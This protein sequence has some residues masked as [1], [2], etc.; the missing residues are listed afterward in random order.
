MKGV[1]GDAGAALVVGGTSGLGWAL[2]QA[3][4]QRGY[5]VVITG[6]SAERALELAAELGGRAE[7]LALDLTKPESLAAA[8][9]EVGPITRLCLVA[10][11][12]SENRVRSFDVFAGVQLA[13]AKLVG[14][15]EV[16]HVLLP[17][18][19]EDCSVLLV[20]G[21]A[22]KQPYD[23]STSVTTVNGGVASLVRSLAVELAPIRV[24]GLHPGPIGDSAFWQA[25]DAAVLAAV[26][27]R[28]L[29]GTLPKTSAVVGAALFLL[30][31]PSVTGVN[32]DVDSGALLAP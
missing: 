32:L 26:S 13:T 3:L 28:T 17:N 19:T 25:A 24:N 7:G 22:R 30:E 29:T 8:L 21:H 18:L 2:A 6:R 23:G 12:S 14:Y 9:G 20:G 16:I 4:G 27:A 10:S 5:G 11:V 1:H 31:N 15:A